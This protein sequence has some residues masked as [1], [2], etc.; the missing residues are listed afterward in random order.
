VPKYRGMDKYDWIKR[1]VGWRE[2]GSKILTRSNF[3]L[4]RLSSASLCT[5]L[6]LQGRYLSNQGLMACFRKE[7]DGECTW[8]SGFSYLLKC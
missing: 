5:F 3:C 7:M 6:W 1:G 4:F 8:T 2:E